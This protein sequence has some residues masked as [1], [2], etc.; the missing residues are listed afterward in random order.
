MCGIAGLIDF[1]LRSSLNNL[2]SM[3]DILHHRGPDDYGYFFEN[4]EQAQIGLGHRRLSI[5]DLSNHGH[6]PMQFDYLTIIYNGEI[7]NFKEIR[8][9][10]EKYGYTFESNSDTE[11]ILKAYHKWGIAAVH[12]FN[13]MFALA[14]F[15]KKMQTLMLIRD[16]AGVKPLY[17]Y[18]KDNLFMFASEIKSFHEH[19]H[20]VKEINH[21]GISLYLQYGYVPQ[22]KTIFNHTHKLEAG[23]F[24]TID[25]KNSALK[26]EKYWD[27]VDYYNQ[28]KIKIH[29]QEALEESE[30]LIKSACEYRMISDVNVGIFLSGGYDSSLVTALLQ[31]DRSEKLKTFTI[32]FNEHKFSEAHHAKRVAEY[33][34][35]DHTEYCCSDSEALQII[36]MIAD[37]WDEPFADNS[38]IP[39]VL[40]SKIARETV[41]V[42][43]SADGGDELFGGYHRYIQSENLYKIIQKIPFRHK[44][45]S[46][47]LKV[48]PCKLNSF[49][50]EKLDHRYYKIIE[51]LGVNSCSSVMRLA[52][53]FFTPLEVN[54]Y[55]LTK[56]DINYQFLDEPNIFKKDIHNLDRMLAID[57]NTFQLDD[58]LVKT[59]R[60]T[61]SAS[62]E[63]REPLLDYRLVEFASRLDVKFKINGGD[64][65][66][67][68]K[69]ITH[70]YINKEILDRPKMGFNSPI[71]KW[72]RADSRKNLF[73]YLSHDYL[74]KQKIFNPWAVTKLKNDYSSGKTDNIHKLWAILVFQMW[75]ERWM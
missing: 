52:S 5:L 2:C 31:T 75:H 4:T 9:E 12:H 56:S 24:L 35:T 21:D 32:S 44:L 19:P 73:D 63:G 38:T 65:K 40:L 70:K 69:K 23:H 68:L 33:L 11:V 51:S 29:E 39:T 22:P 66:Y 26:I 59:D 53:S 49:K 16:R 8:C 6:Q 43:L 37:I 17:W 64:K 57:Y 3:T 58:I 55:L 72:I 42:S 15:D 67:L 62:L 28:P 1:K 27:V 71:E 47:L 30:R 18:K 36:P 60:A 25:I 45:N 48:D 54:N 46:M 50:I 13:G 14:I 41:K 10:L 7:Y 20:F 61:M 34:G 74:E